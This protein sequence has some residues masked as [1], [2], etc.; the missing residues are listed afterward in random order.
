MNHKNKL[1]ELL[2]CLFLDEKFV[3]DCYC[4]I[5]QTLIMCELIR[6]YHTHS[7]NCFMDIIATIQEVMVNYK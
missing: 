1:N 3:C 6:P 5:T 7:G 4:L 2:A